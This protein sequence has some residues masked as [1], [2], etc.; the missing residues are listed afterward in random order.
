[1]EICFNGIGETVATFIAGAGV[2][3]GMPVKMTGN[4]T[5]GAC[6]AG[7][8]FCGVALN[9]RCGYAAVQLAGYAALPYDGT[10]P[11]VGWQSLS[12]AEGGK[13]AVA[14]TGGRQHLVLDVDQTA[15]TCGLIL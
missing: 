12:A 8:D 6:A 7:D 10:A 11:A 15:G 4:G 14:A 2:T 3:A 5:V 13:I 9:V 1:M